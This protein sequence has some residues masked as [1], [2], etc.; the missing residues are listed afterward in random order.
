M[1][2]IGVSIAE[3]LTASDTVETSEQNGLNGFNGLHGGL[4]VA[5]LIHKMRTLVPAHVDLVAVTSRFIRPLAWPIDVDA[6][7]VRNGATVT[8]A[9]ASAS[10]AS[11]ISVEATATFGTGK[12]RDTPTLAPEMPT[13]IVSRA[14]ATVFVIP[15]EFVPI[16]QRLEIRAAT[17]E[18]PYSGTADAVL[19]GWV[20]LRDD[21]PAGDERIAILADS[22]APSY[23]ALLTELKAV[24]TVEMSV[25]LAAGAADSTFDWVLIL[26]RTTSADAHGFIRETIDMWTEGGQYLASCTQL[27]IVR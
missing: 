17:N 16:S 20:R 12:S 15:P 26:A 4:A 18:L 1:V 27:R 22:L 23:T 11:G 21:V 25:Q 13:G 2:T 10:S 14:E 5:M 8:I 6:F 24:P 19:C 7:V 3:F 9:R